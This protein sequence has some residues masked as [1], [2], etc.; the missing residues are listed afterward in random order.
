MVLSR[1]L[2]VYKIHALNVYHINKIMPYKWDLVVKIF[3]S[4]SLLYH[5]KK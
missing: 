4:K 5:A 3:L 2:I 1:T